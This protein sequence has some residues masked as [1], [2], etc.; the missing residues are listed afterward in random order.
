MPP[1]RKQINIYEALKQLGERVLRGEFGRGDSFD[2]EVYCEVYGQLLIPVIFPEDEVREYRE[3]QATCKEA[4]EAAETK[5]LTHNI[6][7]TPEQVEGVEDVEE[8]AND[9]EEKED[10]LI[11]AI[12]AGNPEDSAD[13]SEALGTDATKVGSPGEDILGEGVDG[14]K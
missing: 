10:N 11:P 13:A 4:V 9:S 8:T 1:S 7:P 6:L 3:A 2:E 12:E 14:S 5:E